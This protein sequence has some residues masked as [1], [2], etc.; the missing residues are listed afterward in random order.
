M[1]QDMFYS[2]REEHEL[3]HKGRN[4]YLVYTVHALI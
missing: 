1:R 2:G 3:K 4:L